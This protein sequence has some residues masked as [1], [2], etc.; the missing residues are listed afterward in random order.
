MA[1]DWQVAM[2]PGQ[3]RK[4]EPG[5]L[6]AWAERV[7]ASIRAKVEHPFRDVKGGFGYAKSLPPSPIG[8]PLPGFGQEHGTVGLAAGPVQPEESPTLDSGRLTQGGN[9]PR[10][11]PQ[12]EKGPIPG[13]KEPDPGQIG[14]RT[15]LPKH[16]PSQ[17]PAK[18]PLFR[19]SLNQH[20]F[21]NSSPNSN[22]RSTVRLAATM[23]RSFVQSFVQF[24]TSVIMFRLAL[25][26][27][28]CF[29][30]WNV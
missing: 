14:R 15:T 11:R 19:A 8:G 21:P 22:V 30:A 28:I 12:P 2:R 23:L 17:T 16:C 5:T 6:A 20:Q 27:G 7:K 13:A 18:P 1:V 25:R 26:A 29:G 10:L 9:G 3:R 4:L 24:R